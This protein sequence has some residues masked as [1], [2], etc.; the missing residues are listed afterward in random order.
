MEFRRF[1]EKSDEKVAPKKSHFALAFLAGG[2]LV[3]V[4][5]CI[6]TAGPPGV[7]WPCNPQT[8]LVRGRH[9]GHNGQ[10]VVCP[11][12]KRPK[13]RDASG[14]DQTSRQHV[15]H[16]PLVFLAV[17]RRGLE[18]SA[19]SAHT[20]IMVRCS[21]QSTRDERCTQ[22]NNEERRDDEQ[23]NRMELGE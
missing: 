18:V 21:T 16:R 6:V 22:P 14:E 3:T 20:T 13:I 4:D 15:L 12:K 1:G 19:R 17:C 11:R 10:M 23:H 7:M 2:V 8:N 5:Q 9:I